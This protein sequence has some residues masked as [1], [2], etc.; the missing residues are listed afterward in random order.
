MARR[1][2]FAG[3]GGAH[4]LGSHLRSGFLCTPSLRG[5]VSEELPPRVLDRCQALQCHSRTDGALPFAHIRLPWTTSKTAPFA[6]GSS[7]GKS[8]PISLP[9]TPIKQRPDS[10]FTDTVTGSEIDYILLSPSSSSAFGPPQYARRARHRGSTPPADGALPV[11]QIRLPWSKPKTAPQATDASGKSLPISLPL[12]PAKQRPDSLFTDTVT[13]C[14]TDAH[15]QISAFGPPQYA[16]DIE[17]GA[18]AEYPSPASYDGTDSEG[19]WTPTSATADVESPRVPAP[20]RGLPYTLPAPMPPRL[21]GAS[22]SP[23]LFDLRHLC[24]PSPLLCP[25]PPLLSFT[26]LHPIRYDT[27]PFYFRPG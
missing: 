3:N 27:I 19:Q 8:L 11:P 9:I 10:L 13:G 1:Q 24:P 6:T 25:P 21:D 22:L 14:D 16:R 5:G 17:E 4:S 20:R 23:Y 12:T 2:P 15:S 26:F 7:S 18:Y